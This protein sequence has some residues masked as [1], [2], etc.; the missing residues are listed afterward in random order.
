MRGRVELKSEWE[1]W[2]DPKCL[3]GQIELQRAEGFDDFISLF[4]N[5]LNLYPSTFF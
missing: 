5:G 4:I 3:I 1:A 2:E